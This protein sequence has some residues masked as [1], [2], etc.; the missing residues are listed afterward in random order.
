MKLAAEPAVRR[1]ALPARRA[2][3]HRRAAGTGDRPSTRA[4]GRHSCP[5]D[6]DQRARQVRHAAARARAAPRS[7]SRCL[8]LA[9]VPA[10]P[11]SRTGTPTTMTAIWSPVPTRWRRCSAAV[12]TAV[13]RCRSGCRRSPGAP[14][15]ISTCSTS[16]T[17]MTC[18][19]CAAWCGLARAT[20]SHGLPRRSRPPAACRPE[21]TAATCSPIPR[22]W[23]ARHRWL[24]HACHLP[25]GRPRLP[26]PG[27]TGGVRPLDGEARCRVAVERGTGRAA[28]RQRAGAGEPDLRPCQG[29]NGRARLD[30]FPRPLA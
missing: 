23:P 25:L 28:R 19:G 11:C 30:R 3:G 22:P 16:P 7:R 9:R 27:A 6:A 14:G 21:C 13:S 1:R 12:R 24:R 29:R 8:R 2:R 18:T 5:Q 26:Q 15:L 10:S 17:T 4:R 20:A